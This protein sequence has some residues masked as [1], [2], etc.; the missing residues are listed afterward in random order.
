M[1]P[2]SDRR[3]SLFRGTGR[4][5]G[6]RRAGSSWREKREFSHRFAFSSRPTIY[7]VALEEIAIASALLEPSLVL[8]GPLA[9]RVMHPGRSLRHAAP[10]RT[11]ARVRGW[12][13]MSGACVCRT[14]DC[15]DREGG[16]GDGEGRVCGCITLIAG[17]GLS[18]E[19][20]V[21][22]AGGWKEEGGKVAACAAVTG[23]TKTEPDPVNRRGGRKGNKG[24]LPRLSK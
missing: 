2:I 9:Q 10:I 20:R 19:H 22:K 8:S 15:V 4:T 21:T 12:M 3:R 14:R 16:G 11:C 5:E 13:G 17:R 23:R 18:G 1:E 7:F 24:P 6:R